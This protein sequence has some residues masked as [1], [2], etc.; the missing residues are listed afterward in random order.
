MALAG[1]TV[2]VAG[3]PLVFTLT[4]LAATYAGRCGGVLWAVS[5]DDG[6]LR[7]TYTLDTLPVW[8][9]MAA[10]GSRLYLATA[11]GGLTCMDSTG[12]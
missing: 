4:D 8:D 5:T 3:A 2:F 6:T 7:T 12:D 10:A 11:D 9:G 1:D